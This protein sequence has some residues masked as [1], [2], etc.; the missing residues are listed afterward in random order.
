MREWWLSFQIKCVL[1][2]RFLV[3]FVKGLFSRR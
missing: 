2:W 1:A 3:E